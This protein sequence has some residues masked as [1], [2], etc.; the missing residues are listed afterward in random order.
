MRLDLFD[1]VRYDVRVLR[2]DVVT[3]A[4]I[5]RE[6]EEKR[7]VVLGAPLTVVVRA[8]GD[9]VRLVC[10]LSHRTKLAVRVVEQQLARTRAGSDEARTQIDAVDDTIARDLGAREPGGG[11]EQ[12]HR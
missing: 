1:E 10:A 5:F 8:A 9:E 11:C 4:G 7:W 6:V 3:L 2:G 12:I